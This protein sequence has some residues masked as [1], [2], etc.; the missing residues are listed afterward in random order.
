M[1]II[2][3]TTAERAVNYRWEEKAN[4]IDK[5]IVFLSP[6][7]VNKK[8]RGY[9]F[10]NEDFI[11][12]MMLVMHPYKDNCFVKLDKLEETS[13]NELADELCTIS[14]YLGAKSIKI[15][16]KITECQTLERTTPFSV[17]YKPL[18]LNFD[19]KSNVMQEKEKQYSR[20][21]RFGNNP[22]TTENYQKAVDM[23][24]ELGLYNHKNFKYLF[25]NRIPNGPQVEERTI[26]ITTTEKLN[27]TKRIAASLKIAN[28]FNISEDYT[29]SISTLNKIE[30][31]IQMLFT[32][33]ESVNKTV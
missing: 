24:T 14:D 22:L 25:K 2:Y 21:E 23:A 5:D 1:K 13:L 18:D 3:I 29:K 11:E 9:K 26:H 27:E 10:P 28:I 30:F 6:N 17:V 12:G 16:S 33:K 8:Y 31:T 15:E 7:I 20:Y 32:D 4:T 19:V